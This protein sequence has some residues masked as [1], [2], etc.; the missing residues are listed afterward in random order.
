M[1]VTQKAKN[2]GCLLM[3]LLLCVLLAPGHRGWDQRLH[4]DLDDSVHFFQPNCASRLQIVNP[5]MHFKWRPTSLVLNLD[6]V[7][8]HSDVGVLDTAR[9]IESV[10]N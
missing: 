3:S 7:S 4:N 10:A 1:E 5:R 6:G 9:D 2:K 8:G